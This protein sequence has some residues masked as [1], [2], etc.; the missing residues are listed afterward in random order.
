MAI[1]VTCPGCR[2][3]PFGDRG[4][5][6]QDDSVQEVPRDLHGE[7]GGGR[8]WPP[9]ASTT[10]SESLPVEVD[11]DEFSRATANRAAVGSHQEQ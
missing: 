8:R 6:G 5:A 7:S 10:T 11:D 1:T 3:T 4:F 9:A 2:T